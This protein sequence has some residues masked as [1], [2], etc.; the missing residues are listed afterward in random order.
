MLM[1]A[2]GIATTPTS[3]APDPQPIPAAEETMTVPVL[4]ATDGLPDT[5][6]QSTPLWEAL[7][8]P[9]RRGQK[10]RAF[11]VYD[12]GHLYTW[13]HNRRTINDAGRMQ[14]VRA[15]A[16]WR[17]DARVELTPIR[18]AIGQGFLDLDAQVQ[19]KTSD[20]RW[21]V[22]RALGP[23]GTVHGVHSPTGQ[24]PDA[25]RTV[26]LAVQQAVVPSAVPVDNGK[27]RPV[28]K[29]SASR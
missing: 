21:R 10:L 6:L 14:R 29:P 23:D 25:A 20:G 7:V 13:S 5:L 17:L 9:D 28:A 27:A 15:P 12:D 11:R 22:W 26:E 8:G 24:V 3:A 2:C 1:A 18:E 4:D 19:G 16:R